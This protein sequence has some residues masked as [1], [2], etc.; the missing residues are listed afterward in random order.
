MNRLYRLALPFGIIG[1]VWTILFSIL[2]F[3][4]I[5]VHIGPVTLEGIGGEGLRVA[6]PAIHG[7]AL[8]PIGS[9]AIMGM[10]GLV[11]T[12]SCKRRR[13]LK[14]VLMWVSALAILALSLF[15]QVLFLLPAAILL[16]LAAVGT[17]DYEPPVDSSISR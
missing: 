16:I 11:A 3:L 5:P 12:L 4:L 7:G 13:R 8:I 15:G 10:L 1:G 2:M 6:E 9:T 17:K 14:S